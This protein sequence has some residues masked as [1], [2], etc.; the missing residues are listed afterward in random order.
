MN[1]LRTQHFELFQKAKI[2]DKRIPLRYN[3]S[4]SRNSITQALVLSIKPQGENNRSVCLLTKDRGIIYA[5]LYGGPK[6]RLRS[7]VSPWNSGTIYLYTDEVRN[8]TKITDF[9]VKQFH[10]TFRENLFKS[11]AASLAAEVVLKTKCAGSIE[12]CYSLLN[13]FLDGLDIVDENEGRL[14]LIRFLWR[15]LYLLG[16]SPDTRECSNCSKSFFTG[17]LSSNNVKLESQ[18]VYFSY[19]ENAFI[20]DDCGITSGINKDYYATLSCKALFYLDVASGAEMQVSRNLKI[21]ESTVNE[22]KEFVFYMI[23]SD[24]GTRL[25][26]LESGMGIL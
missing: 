26:S 19:S 12:P 14:G 1:N 15:Y 22:L 16:V 10:P 4:M 23:E 13:G 24:C 7:M 8:S 5:I 11:W 18:N 21:D 3:V 9:D 2:N 17:N 25:K 6:S 20:C